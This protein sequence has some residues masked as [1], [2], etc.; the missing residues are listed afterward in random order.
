[1]SRSALELVN[2]VPKISITCRPA[3]H[4]KYLKTTRDLG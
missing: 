2:N 3:A 4:E 1:M